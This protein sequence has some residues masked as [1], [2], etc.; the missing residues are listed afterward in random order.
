MGSW[1]QCLFKCS[2][3]ILTCS[4][5]W[6][7]LGWWVRV[8]RVDFSIETRTCSNL[9]FSN[10]ALGGSLRNPAHTTSLFPHLETPGLPV[11]P[12]QPMKIQ[13]NWTALG[14]QDQGLTLLLFSTSVAS[15]VKPGTLPQ[16]ESGEEG[17]GGMNNQK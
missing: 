9:Q 6:D 13:T 14:S 16:S 4:Q 2:Q 15:D 3:V 8:K 11:M 7:P 12:Q 1:S 17:R 5:G 10:W